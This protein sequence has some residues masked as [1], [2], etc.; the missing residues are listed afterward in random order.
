MIQ[1]IDRAE[2]DHTPSRHRHQPN[3]PMAAGPPRVLRIGFHTVRLLLGGVFI[4]ASYDK[5]LK[6]QAFAQ[7]VYNYQILPD[8][9][10]NLTALVLPWLELLIG[11][12]LVIGLWLPG[13]TIITTGL[14]TLFIGAL[15]FNLSR[16]LDVHCGCFSTETIAGPVDA[17]IVVRDLLFVAASLFLTLYVFFLQP[18]DSNAREGSNRSRS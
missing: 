3:P 8:A 12:C 10:V 2:Q 6:P 17:W 1:E 14:L 18:S 13:T 16:G 5:I 7:A 15:V 4:Y 9:V 11:I